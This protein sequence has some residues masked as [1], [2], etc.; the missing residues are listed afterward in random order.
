[1]TFDLS[2]FSARRRDV[3]FFKF[4][5]TKIPEWSPTDLRQVKGHVQGVQQERRSVVELFQKLEHDDAGLQKRLSEEAQEEE[6][7]KSAW[8]L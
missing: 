2:A 3:C 7:Q 5:G 1:M 6:R 8:S 4:L